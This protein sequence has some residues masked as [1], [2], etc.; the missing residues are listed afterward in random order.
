MSTINPYLQTQ[1]YSPLMRRLP[2]G[3]VPFHGSDAWDLYQGGIHGEGDKP[4]GLENVLNH[5]VNLMLDGALMALGGAAIAKVLPW[6]AAFGVIIAAAGALHLGGM[7]FL[8]GFPE[9]GA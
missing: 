8:P 4:S 1:G 9:N 6:P 2:D 3:T 5:P 7:F